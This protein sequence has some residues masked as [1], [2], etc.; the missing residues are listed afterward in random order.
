[1]RTD[2]FCLAVKLLWAPSDEG[3]VAAQTRLRERKLPLSRVL[4]N[5]VS[6]ALPQETKLVYYVAR[7][8]FIATAVLG[9]YGT[10][11]LADSSPDKGSPN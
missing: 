1:M 11:R 4:T 2:K 6:L 5:F 9:R 10:W 3:A 8:F 7:P